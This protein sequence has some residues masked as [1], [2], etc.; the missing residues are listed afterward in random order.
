MTI[1][2]KLQRIKQEEE[3]TKKVR[4]LMEMFKVPNFPSYQYQPIGASSSVIDPRIQMTKNLF[5][6]WHL[7][8]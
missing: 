7:V 6:M 1:R 2:L 4:D 8:R 5:E 3:Q